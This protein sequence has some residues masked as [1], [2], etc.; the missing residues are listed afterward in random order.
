MLSS[1]VTAI[2]Y[3]F[4]YSTWTICS[5]VLICKIVEL[6]ETVGEPSPIFAINDQL[7]LG[8]PLW[9][10]LFYGFIPTV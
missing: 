1:D 10:D 6:L 2:D 9:A 7:A 8:M 4:D 3:S 5:N